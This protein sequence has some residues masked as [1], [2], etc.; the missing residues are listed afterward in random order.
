MN[1]RHAF[2]AGNF[3]DVVKHLALISI[4]S[5]LKKK[6]AGFAVVDTHAGRGVYDLGSEE[7]RRGG[8]AEAGIGRIA[9][10]ADGPETLQTY[11]RLAE[12]PRYPGSPLIAARLIRPQ[13]RLVAIEKHP[14]DAKTLAATLSP[15]RRARTVEGDGYARL[16][17][18]LPPPERRGLVLIDPPY[19][20]PGEF[21]QAA[22]AVAAALERFATGIVMIWFPIKSAPAAAAFAGEV[23]AA[24]PRKA[25]RL[26]VEVAAQ[27]ETK[28]GGARTGRLAAAGLL[29]VNPPYG[30]A[31]D[32]RQALDIVAPRLDGTARLD[33]L[34]GA[35]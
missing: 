21:G 6:E 12:G 32:M 14:D 4:L 24:G 8:E 26:D 2:H 16:P 33:W 10:I 35:E 11:L 3:A 13:D 9:G 20:A 27:A 15:F 19:E 5:H 28:Q 17:A 25:L 22:R 23:L 29:V 31:A 7:A 1:Y 18:L 30:F 34:A